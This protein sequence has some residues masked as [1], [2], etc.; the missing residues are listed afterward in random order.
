VAAIRPRAPKIGIALGP[1]L[2]GHGWLGDSASMSSV[3]GAAAPISCKIANL[4]RILQR[5]DNS[6]Q[7]K[8]SAKE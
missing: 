6:E 7:P 2:A 3:V 4:Y 5:G 8:G 1:P